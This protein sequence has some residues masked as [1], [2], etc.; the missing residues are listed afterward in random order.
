MRIRYFCLYTYSVPIMHCLHFANRPSYF[1]TQSANKVFVDS[2]DV[3]SHMQTDAPENRAIYDI[4][5]NVFT[6]RLNRGMLAY[7][8]IND[9]WRICVDV[10][11]DLVRHLDQN[12]DIPLERYDQVMPFC[13]M[14][15]MTVLIRNAR[16]CKHKIETG[17][18]DVDSVRDDLA[19][20]TASLRRL[21]TLLGDLNNIW[22]VE[23]VEYLMR[24][25]QVEEV[26][27]AADLLSGLSL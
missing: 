18:D 13:L 10:V 19:Q 21:W 17:A 20:S 24:I 3:A 9:S 2:P 15:S 7:D 8:V 23:G 6:D 5:A 11:H 4:L 1:E 26:V 27:N 14:T 25:M 16:I 12:K 22:R